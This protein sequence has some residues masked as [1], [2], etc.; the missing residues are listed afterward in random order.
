MSSDSELSA[1][2]KI[3]RSESSEEEDEMDSF[4]E[5][6]SKENHPEEAAKKE[7]AADQEGNEKDK[8]EGGDGELQTISL[9]VRIFKQIFQKCFKD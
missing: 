7:I 1:Q 2:Q 8:A 5:D 3:I 4:D 9:E 6:N